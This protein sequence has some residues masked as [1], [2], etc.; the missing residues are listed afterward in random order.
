MVRRISKPLFAAIGFLT[1]VPI[2]ERWKG[3]GDELARSIPFLPVVGA[4]LGFAAAGLDSLVLRHL[5]RGVAAVLLV[6][7][8][9]AITGGL[10]VDG[11]A[12]T[13]DGFLSS[14][15]RARILEIMKDRNSGPMGVA[16]VVCVLSLKIASLSAIATPTLKATAVL[17]MPLAGRSA[18]VIAMT[19]LPYTRP[20]GGTGAVF[21]E[22]RS[23]AGL[24][25]ALA[26]P[27]GLG[28]WIGRG[29]GLALA[30]GAFAAAVAMSIWSW[31]KIGGWTGDTL[32]ATCEVA[33]A[34][35][36]VGWLGF[37]S[38]GLS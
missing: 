31:R 16:A 7:A 20:E 12:D 11:L 25:V 19:L 33:E 18:T 35:A 36:L 32:G 37:A 34:V 6:T 26:A 29:A 38:G 5:P 3:S 23:W 27:V 24:V 1:I 2:P 14:R 15:P 30:G 10:H 9:V 22:H 17:L 8:L 13:A 28:W 4:M 21:A